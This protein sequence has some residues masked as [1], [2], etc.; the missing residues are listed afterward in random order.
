MKTV[1]EAVLNFFLKCIRPK[2][3]VSILQW[4]NSN[5]DTHISTQSYSA[6]YK[7]TYQILG[8]K[9]LLAATSKS[10]LFFLKLCI[11]DFLWQ[12]S[13]IEEGSKKKPEEVGATATP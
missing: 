7:Y 1:L 13:Y 3:N 12:P 9:G 2:V 6:Q 11:F 4:V 8:K 5:K 10:P